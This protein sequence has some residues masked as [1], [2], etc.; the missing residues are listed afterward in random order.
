MV[1]IFNQ[2]MPNGN[3]PLVRDLF[4]NVDLID[5]DQGACLKTSVFTPLCM[6][7]GI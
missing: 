6:T 3:Q 5:H 2:L 1:N 7:E 4:C